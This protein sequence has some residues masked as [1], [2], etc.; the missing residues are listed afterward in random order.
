MFLAAKTKG[1]FVEQNDHAILLART[2]APKPPLIVEQVVECPVGD[3]VAIAD[4]IKRLQPKKSPSGYLNAVCGTYANRRLVRRATVELKRLKEPGY[5]AELLST[6]FR[7]ELDKY[8]I[9]VLNAPD[10]SDFD[11]VQAS[12]KEALFCGLPTDDVN[13]IQDQLLASGI[14]PQRL[15]VSS[16][17]VLGAVIDYLKWKK[18]SAPTLLLEFGLEG[19][20]SFIVTPEGV[21]V[22]RPI[23]V[24]LDSFVPV[25]QKELGLKDTESARKLL[26]S[27]TFD[28]TGMAPQLLK[29]LLKELQSSIGFYEVQT[30]QSV[31]QVLSTAL[32]S[33][34]G[35][36][37]GSVAN[38]LSLN[39]LQLELAPWLAS[40]QVTLAPTVAKLET[41]WL[42]LFSLMVNYTKSDVSAAETK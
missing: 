33:A 1:F 29:R 42:G 23:P 11:L 5:F 9:H 34:L 31:G 3:G 15:E 25:V 41:R 12:Q 40:R 7:V 28:F 38:A 14:F 24:G 13:A 16:V 17:A 32:P 36:L 20:H 8:I 4:A 37:D 21:D 39:N 30:G 18:L 26:F 6:Q 35:W 19:T 22:A 10:G 2:S 27:N